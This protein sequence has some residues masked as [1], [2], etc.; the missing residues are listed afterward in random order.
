MIRDMDSSLYNGPKQPTEEHV[1]ED[2]KLFPN[3]QLP[4]VYIY[5]A[6]LAMTVYGHVRLNLLD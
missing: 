1:N 3:V 4:Q 2:G 6:Y 5:P